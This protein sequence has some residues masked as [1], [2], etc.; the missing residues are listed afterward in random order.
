MAGARRAPEPELA[1]RYWRF[2]AYGGNENAEVEFAERLR[3][4]HVLAKP[5]NGDAEAIR[6][7]ER[8]DSQG[9]ARAALNLARAYSAQGLS[10]VERKDLLLAMKYAYRA[11]DLSVK[12]SPLCGRRQSVL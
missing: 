11:I 1:E 10:G 8:A 3:L 12:A 2:A 9:S 6:L 4:G 5:E 7:W